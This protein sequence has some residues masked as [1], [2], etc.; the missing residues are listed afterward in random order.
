MNTASLSIEV[1]RGGHVE[2]RH[3]VDFVVVDADGGRV[4]ARGDV[5]RP[6]FP[7]SA[8]KVIQALPLVES[9]AADALGFSDRELAFVSASHNGEPEHVAAAR[10]LLA[11]VGRDETCLAC[12]PQW[13]SRE[14]DRGALHRAGR[15]P[16]RLHNNC[17]GKHAG[18]VCAV[19]HQAIDPTGY[20]RIDH[21]LQRQIAA[22]LADVTGV[23]LARAPV[24]I[25]GCSIPTWAIPLDALAHGFA[26]LTTGVGLE[27]GRAAAAAR[28]L[29]AARAHPF[30]IAGTGRV[31]TDLIEA[32]GGRIYVKVGAEGV[33]VASLPEEG[34]AVA[35]KCADGATRA[36]EVAVATIVA[37]LTGRLEDP[38]L[39]RFLR[40]PIEDR[41]G[42]TVGELRCASP[43]LA[44]GS[45]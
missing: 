23:D 12:G 9:G 37:A 3:A 41:N 32:Y 8:I 14:E 45:R 17:S 16:S 6:V 38:A 21:P 15:G 39:A 5:G 13:P 35:L 34:L 43:D 26:K 27:P 19:C 18:F 36:A 2:S 40:P 30:M 42:A 25:D 22:A 28:L 10:D 7:R 4:A 33:Y 11:R 29:A 31:C 1:L 24:G 20:E 44:R